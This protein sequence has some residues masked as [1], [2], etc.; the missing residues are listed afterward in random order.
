MP[1]RQDAKELLFSEHLFWIAMNMLSA[2]TQLATQV[3]RL[4]NPYGAFGLD[5]G[6]GEVSR[7]QLIEALIEFSALKL[8]D[9]R[10]PTSGLPTRIA[11]AFDSG[12]AA[13]LAIA[14]RQRLPDAAG[15]AKWCRT[16]WRP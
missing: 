14:R 8:R 16:S 3:L 15:G 9:A 5:T 6:T 2:G 1:A 10:E 12:Y 7:E 13:L 11:A 4:P